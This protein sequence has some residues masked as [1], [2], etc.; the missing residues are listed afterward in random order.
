MRSFRTHIPRDLIAFGSDNFFIK[1]GIVGDDTYEHELQIGFSG[2]K[3]LIKLD[4]KA[5]TSYKE[6][7]NYYRVVT[8]TED[9]LL[10]IKSGPELGDFS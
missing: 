8:I 4:Q 5:L 10:L 7:T 9:D 1:V 3:R 2:K 6:L